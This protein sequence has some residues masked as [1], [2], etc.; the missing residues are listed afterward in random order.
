[1][2]KQDFDNDMYESNLISLLD[3]E[4]NE[5][6][7]E[8][9]EELDYNDG[10]YYALMPLFDMPDDE[11]EDSENVYMIFEDIIDEN[12]EPQLAE[13]DDEALLDTLAEM[14]EEKF[15]EALEDDDDE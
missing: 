4:G 9:I 14:F 6:E 1:M 8:I 11:D 2:S 7:F 12:G 15:D 10:H 3:D 13:I 5:Y